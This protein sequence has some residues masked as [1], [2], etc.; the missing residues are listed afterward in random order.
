MVRTTDSGAGKSD[1]NPPVTIQT[2][3][4]MRRGARDIFP[5]A[6]FVV[7][8]G[9][10]F[11]VA[12]AEAGMTPLTATLMSAAVMAGASQFTALE[13]WSAPIALVPLLL[14]VFAVNARHILLGAS[15]Y[16]WM[17]GLPHIRR[18]LSVM[19]MTDANWAYAVQQ[20]RRGEPDIGILVGS[21]L[22][23]WSAWV[24]GTLIGSS[25]TGAL[26]DPETL[27]LDTVM[28]A[29]F[30]TV[31]VDFARDRADS[32]VWPWLVAALVAVVSSWI[33]PPGWH[34]LAGGVAGGAV[35]GMAH[36]N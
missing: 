24:I 35:G 26:I 21:G 8:F 5:I 33:L 11:G 36:Q 2:L 31:L 3:A 14:V 16:P 15:I 32:V 7:P 25:F 20:H 1:S 27:A 18:H 34:I 6:L 17:R 10:A 9:I 29:F 4:G 28:V 12:A 19:V 22:T 23:M 13:F 30:A